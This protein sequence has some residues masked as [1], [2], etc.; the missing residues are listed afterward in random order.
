MVE[1]TELGVNNRLLNAVEYLHRRLLEFNVSV[2]RHISVHEMPR[3]HSRVGLG[4]QA[5]YL[6]VPIAMISEMRCEHFRLEATLRNILVGLIGSIEAPRPD[7]ARLS[8]P[9][10]IHAAILV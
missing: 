1:I 4:W 8:A 7:V 3:Q 5:F 10:H 6:Y 2:L 9:R